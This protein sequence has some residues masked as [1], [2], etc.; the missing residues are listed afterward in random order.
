MD[1]EIGSARF[2]TEF[3]QPIGPEARVDRLVGQTATPHPHHLRRQR[4]RPLLHHGPL[5]L[6]GEGRIEF[7]IFHLHLTH[8]KRRGNAHDKHRNAQ[9][10][11][12]LPGL[13]CGRIVVAHLIGEHDNHHVAFRHRGAKDAGS[14]GRRPN[15]GE[16]HLDP[17]FIDGH[18][19]DQPHHFCGVGRRLRGEEL[20][21]LA[22]GDQH[23]GQVGPMASGTV[24]P[25]FLKHPLEPL[26]NLLPLC[27]Q[28]HRT[29]KQ[30]AD[31]R[32]PLSER[33]HN[34]GGESVDG[35]GRAGCNGAGTPPHHHGRIDRQRRRQ[36]LGWVNRKTGNRLLRQHIQ[37]RNGDLGERRGE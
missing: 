32:W 15:R 30:P 3:R 23:V 24:G 26:R 17:C 22:V 27:R 10:A 21:I 16:C 8:A 7:H 18:I 34:L 25:Q 9:R 28:A 11:T 36:G 37:R 14:L 29:I 4:F 5:L 1:A 2:S 31:Q 13:V 6:R 19:F 33:G 12:E 35:T 20:Q